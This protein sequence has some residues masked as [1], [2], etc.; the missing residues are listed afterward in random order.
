MK[1]TAILIALGMLFYGSL[2][3]TW[4]C[5]MALMNNWPYAFPFKLLILHQG[6]IWV[7]ADFWITLAALS[8]ITS[9]L[10]RDRET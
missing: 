4:E 10:I 9:H 6:D 5:V 1:R 2:W 8:F 7:V 3:Q